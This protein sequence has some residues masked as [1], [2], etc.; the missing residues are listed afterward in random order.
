MKILLLFLTLFL[1]AKTNAQEK[2]PAS[3][4]ISKINAG[5][6]IDLKNVTIMGTLDL[7]K[8]ENCRL[9]SNG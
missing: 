4:I 2:I 7:T 5:T 3:D 6:K 8:L 1:V 9:K